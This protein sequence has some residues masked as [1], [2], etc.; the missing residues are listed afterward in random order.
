MKVF[1]SKGLRQYEGTTAN[2]IKSLSK[3]YSEITISFEKIQKKD[4]IILK[5]GSKI[6]ILNP[7]GNDFLPGV[8]NEI[9]ESVEGKKITVQIESNEI[10]QF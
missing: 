8:I 3:T 5:D 10:F 1:F 4:D 9:V 2:G 7:N 6:D